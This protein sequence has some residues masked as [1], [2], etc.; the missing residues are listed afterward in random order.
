MVRTAKVCWT[1]APLLYFSLQVFVAS[2]WPVPYELLHHTISD[3]GW[4]TCTVEQR[5]SGTLAS[6]SPRHAWFNLGGIAVRILLAAGGILLKP[7]YAAATRRVIAGWLVIAGFGIA[8]CLV[9]G[10]V[11]PALH[12]LL[13]IPVFLGTV[14]VLFASARALSQTA[15]FAARAATVTAVVSLVGV[16]G[17][18]AAL[19]GHG[20]VGLTER[21]AAETIYLW[22]FLTAVW[23]DRAGVRAGERQV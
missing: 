14:A 22:V 8:T 12:A 7:L 2:A 11:N 6:C 10:D 5:L 20:P 9:P 15:R 21:L 23:P 3:L 18:I 17:L 1:L 13:A 19:T 16:L 4:T